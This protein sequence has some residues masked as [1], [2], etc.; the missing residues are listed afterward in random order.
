VL[1]VVLAGDQKPVEAL[2]SNGADEALGVRIGLGRL[3]RRL[4]NGE[5]FALEDV[6]AGGGELRVAISDHKQRRWPGATG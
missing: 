1:E 2:A 3:D 6:V 5:A 4:D